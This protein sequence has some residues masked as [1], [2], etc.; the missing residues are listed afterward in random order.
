MPC[1]QA[2]PNAAI[3][4]TVDKTIALVGISGNGWFGM[5]ARAFLGITTTPAMTGFR[6]I[7][8]SSANSFYISGG[9][10]SASGFLFVANTTTDYAAPIV[11][12]SPGQAGYTD[13]RGIVIY[14]NKLYATSGDAGFTNVFKIG[15]TLPTSASR[16]VCEC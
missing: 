10:A 4:T 12:Q 13:A 7:A 1:Y 8:T 14:A 11:G 16:F 6:Q 2:L 5:S 15:S 9:G 3:D